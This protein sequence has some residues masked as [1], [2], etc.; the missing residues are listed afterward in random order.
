MSDSLLPDYDVV[1]VGGGAGGVYTAWRMLLEGPDQSEKLKKWQADRGGRL[2]IGIFEMTDRI[3][4][5]VLSAIPPG[6]PDVVCEI[7]GMRY[8]SSQTWV[9]SLIEN[10]FNLPRHPQ[11][12]SELNNLSY[13]RGKRLRVGDLTDPTKIPYNL[14]AEE[15]EWLSKVPYQHTA[16]NFIGYAVQKAFPKIAEEG[17]HGQALRDYLRTAKFNGVDLYKVGF[18]NLIATQLSHEAYEVAVTTVGYDCLGYNTNAVDAICEYFDFTPGVEYY[19]LDNGYES[20][21][22]KMQ[23]EFQKAGGEVN[24]EVAL[25]GFD[26]TTLPD[27][28]VGVNVEF[29]DGRL[30]TSRAIVLGMPQR[31]LQLLDQRGPILDPDTKTGQHVRHLMNS[32]EPIHLY[33]MFIAYDRPWWEEIGVSKGR[34]LTDIPIRQCYYW[35]S[36]IGKKNAPAGNTNSIIMV[37]NDA[38]SSDYWGGLRDI[39]LGPGDTDTEFSDPPNTSGSSLSADNAGSDPWKQRLH[40]NWKDHVAPDRM[41]AEM[42]RQLK[43]MHGLDDVPEPLEAAFKDWGDDPYG[44]AVH[45]WNPGYDSTKVLNAMIQ[46]VDDFPCYICGEAYSTNQ[47]WV[48]GAFETAEL[49]LRKFDIQKPK[50]VTDEPAS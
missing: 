21:I 47:T 25:D 50:W 17:L 10:K 44:G 35:G 33:K 27:G 31:S 12:V 24:L 9:R 26:A 32:V 4:G 48:E 28:G 40:K 1:I 5:R 23:E 11:A 14:T 18:W 19:L 37:Y 49:L 15:S 43:I 46:P 34:S 16:S 13:L 42:H 22:W 8:V 6:M 7:G 30:V 41:R 20:M 39:P 2:K 36:E 38:I 45:F 29:K 3:G